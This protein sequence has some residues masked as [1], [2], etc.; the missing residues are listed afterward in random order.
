MYNLVTKRAFAFENARVEWVDGNLG[1]HVTMKYPSVYLKG[2]NSSADILSIAY[3][4]SNQHQDAGAKVVHFGKNSNSRIVNK[5]VSKFG[6]H[7]TYRGL[8]KVVKGAI[9]CKINV[10]CDALLLDGNSKTDTFPVIQIDEEDTLLSHEARVGKIGNDEIFYLQS[11]G[12]PE[13]KAIN[14]ILMG[15]LEPFS[16]ELPL[17]YAV[18]LHRLM[19]IEMEGS[20]G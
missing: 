12:I 9:G 15:F 14:M 10:Q 5:S 8:V 7:T 16:K 11:R 18:E 4:G 6:G 17:D 19:E 13:S 3:A 2:D 1:S 20:I